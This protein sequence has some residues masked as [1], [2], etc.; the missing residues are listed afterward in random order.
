MMV[1]LEALH[2]TTYSRM[3]SKD[4]QAGREEYKKTQ[5]PIRRLLR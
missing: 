2:G 3:S 4:E 1:K 5:C